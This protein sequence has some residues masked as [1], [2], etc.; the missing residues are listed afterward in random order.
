MLD[1]MPATAISLPL[2]IIAK[3]LVLGNLRLQCKP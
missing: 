1:A 3:N 2:D